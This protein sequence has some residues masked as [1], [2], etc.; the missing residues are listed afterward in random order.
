MLYMKSN[1]MIH[2][3]K[4]KIFNKGGSTYTNRSL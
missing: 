4:T 2:K 1:K 3:S